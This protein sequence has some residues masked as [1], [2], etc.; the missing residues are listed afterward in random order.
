[1]SR[2][3]H[4][5]RGASTRSAYRRLTRHATAL[6]LIA[7]IGACAD[8]SSP[9]SPAGAAAVPSPSHA[10]TLAVLQSELTADAIDRILPALE[11]DAAAPVGNALRTL[12]AKLR[13]PGAT[14]A[15][16][17]RAAVTVQKVLGQ[18]TDPA[19]V[20]AADLDAMRLEVDAVRAALS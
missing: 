14:T 12:D 11:K 10:T 18:F 4:T 17:D 6:G 9:T 19:R 13:D 20:D 15:A 7:V 8:Q 2:R 5:A 3:F 16:K 1:M